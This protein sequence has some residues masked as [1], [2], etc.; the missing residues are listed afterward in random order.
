METAEWTSQMF[1][2]HEAKFRA[3]FDE[4]EKLFIEE[5]TPSVGRSYLN[6]L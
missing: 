2:G 3:W 4:A 5:V 6:H 1:N